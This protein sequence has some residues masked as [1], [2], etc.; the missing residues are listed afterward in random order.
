M[1]RLICLKFRLRCCVWEI[2]GVFVSHE[3]YAGNGLPVP[4]ANRRKNN[5]AVGIFLM[6]Q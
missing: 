3:V 5:C 1:S 4:G 6:K 2:H